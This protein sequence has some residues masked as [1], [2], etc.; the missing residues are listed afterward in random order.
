MVDDHNFLNQNGGLR[1]M[2]IHHILN[3]DT[4]MA[5]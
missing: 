2:S 3:D 4:A 5:L 1:A